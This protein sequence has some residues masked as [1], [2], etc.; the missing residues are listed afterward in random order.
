[1]CLKAS[2]RNPN[3]LSPATRAETASTI[4]VVG[5]KLT[6][7]PLPRKEETKSAEIMTMGTV[8]VPEK[9]DARAIFRRT[10][11]R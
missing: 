10:T 6:A 9:I 11:A 5:V 4:I 8:T 2:R 1:M 3:T 7:P